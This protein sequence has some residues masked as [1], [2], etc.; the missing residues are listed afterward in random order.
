MR[1]GNSEY[2]ARCD[3]RAGQHP[4]VGYGAKSVVNKLH[5]EKLIERAGAWNEWRAANPG[6]IPDLSH[7]SLTPGQKQF[8]PV[9]GGPINL[10]AVNLF[11]ADLS[12]ATLIEADL[13]NAELAEADL[14]NA[15]LNQADLRGA[16]LTDAVLSGADLAD[17][18]FDQ[19]II[20]GA[21]LSSARNLD[22]SQIDV[23]LGDH[24][25]RLPEGIFQPRSW[26]S[27]LMQEQDELKWATP[28][29]RK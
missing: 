19:A 13:R 6:I 2:G 8:G 3:A 1:A 28:P 5:F 9:N 16:N 21:N 24:T 20:I 4:E 12:N 14:M 7:V 22:Q 18:R 10:S 29:S 25:T 27:D 11:K 23:A 17:V 26:T 15:R